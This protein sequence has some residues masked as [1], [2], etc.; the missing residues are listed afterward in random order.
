MVGARG[1]GNH[2]GDEAIASPVDGLDT[3]LA[4]STV[5]QGFADHHQALRQSTFTDPALGPQMLQE[6]LFGHHAVPMRKEIG[7]NIQGVRL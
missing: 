2:R 1:V 4:P 7:Q 3:V 6:F 5:A